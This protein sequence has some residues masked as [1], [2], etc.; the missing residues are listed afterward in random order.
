MS[1]LACPARIEGTLIRAMRPNENDRLAL[2][3]ML[4][5]IRQKQDFAILLVQE[6]ITEIALPIGS[7]WSGERKRGE[8]DKSEKRA[9]D[10]RAAKRGRRTA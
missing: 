7:R 2:N 4:L 1:V 9:R 10:D 5:E 6:L 8:A 3:D